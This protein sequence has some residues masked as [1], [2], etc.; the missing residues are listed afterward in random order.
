MLSMSY[1]K[2]LPEITWDFGPFPDTPCDMFLDA[3]VLE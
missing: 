3:F 1:H 2:N